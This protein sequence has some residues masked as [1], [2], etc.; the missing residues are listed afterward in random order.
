MS[1]KSLV[2]I[3]PEKVHLLLSSCIN[4]HQFILFTTVLEFWFLLVNSVWS[5]HISGKTHYSLEKAILWIE[6]WVFWVILAIC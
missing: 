2:I 1:P 6:D 5:V 3:P 4:I